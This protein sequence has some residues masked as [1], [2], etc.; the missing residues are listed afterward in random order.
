MIVR[1]LRIRLMLGAAVAI[2]SALA[3]AWLAMTLIFEHHL[4]QRLEAELTAQ[5][6]LLLTDL[7]RNAQ[8]LAI[9]G[10]PADPRY[11]A[12]ASGFYWQASGGGSVLR[13]R[14]LWDQT[15]PAASDAQPDNWTHRSTQGP[16][17]QRLFMLER[18][19]RLDRAGPVVLV[20][21]A[22]D[23]AP[24]SLAITEFGRELALFLLLLW[25]ALSAAAWAQVQLGLAPIARIRRQL[26]LMQQR[27]EKRL[28]RGSLSEI[29]P[30][31]AEINNLADA[32]EA[33]LNRA[34]RRA[35]D[36]AHSLKTPLAALSVQSRK[37]R[38]AGAADAADGLDRAA[39]AIQRA[40]DWELA[41][42][43]IT[44]VRQDGAASSA[45]LP[46]VE[47]LLG[48]LERTERGAELVFEVEIDKA[49]RVPMA[50]DDLTEL[51]GSLVENAVRHA[52]RRVQAVADTTSGVA[53]LIDDD[54]PPDDARAAVS[55]FKRRGRA[56]E[57]GGGLGLSIARDLAEAAGAHFE[58]AMSPLGGMR[59]RI[60]WMREAPA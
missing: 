30:L 59:A 1:S 41:R 32:R 56:D 36:L 54:G 46:V 37:A 29:E 50:A 14:S 39:A 43:R 60:A 45:A 24:M 47:R 26:G 19:V 8:G 40:V 55:A 6:T 23:V 33:D 57:A 10:G 38:A 58:L 27:S 21:L 53:L 52:R 13:S 25:A 49:V 12:P 18:Q 5:A 2:F 51:L 20:Q 34:R 28:P 7:S 35:A 48:V 9:D 4:E 3:L 22:Q 11:D 15:L 31:V 17:G 16:F 44:A 42:A